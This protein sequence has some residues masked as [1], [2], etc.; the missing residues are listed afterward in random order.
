MKSYST[1]RQELK[2][3]PLRASRG[4]VKSPP[5]TL[6][7]EHASSYKSLAA[8]KK[9]KAHVAASING[10]DMNLDQKIGK[11]INEIK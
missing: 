2:Y 5:K 7:S 11:V 1:Q 9:K 3:M 4:S 10:A 6:S 8:A